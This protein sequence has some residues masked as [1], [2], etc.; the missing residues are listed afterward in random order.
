MKNVNKNENLVAV[1]KTSK[2]SRFRLLENTEKVL[3]YN[4]YDKVQRL[5]GIS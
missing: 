4:V 5:R 1:A 3:S 2:D